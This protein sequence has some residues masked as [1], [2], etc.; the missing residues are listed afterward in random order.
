MNEYVKFYEKNNISPVRQN[1]DDFNQHIKRRSSLYRQ[2]GVLPNFF[3]GKKV[4]EVGPGGGYNA[5]ATYTFEPSKYVFVEPNKTGYEE[6]QANFSKY[7]FSNNVEFYNCFL[8]SFESDETFDI[9]ICE[10]LI[11]GLPNRDEFLSQLSNKVADGGILIITSADEISMFF[12]ILRRYLSNEL[13]KNE[14]NFNQQLEILVSAFSS[15]LDTLKG[16]TRRYDD[17][18]ADLI[19]DAIYNHTFSV[20]DAIEYFKEQYFLWSFSKY[21]SRLS[22]V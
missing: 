13:I 6:L 18:C 15:H 17:W 22:M 1:I 8:E 11:Q 10:G 9:V 14:A 12:E 4:L 16:M 21:F 19:C 7:G 3:K 2:L 20:S 5:L